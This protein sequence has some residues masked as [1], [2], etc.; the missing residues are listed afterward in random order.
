MLISYNWLQTYFDKKLPKVS[1][2]SEILTMHSFEVESVEEVNGDFVLDIDILPNRAHDCLSHRG[3]AGEVSSLLGYEL[4]KTESGLIDEKVTDLKVEV[5]DIACRRY[6]GKV[7]EDIKVGSSPDWLKERLEVIG[8]KS[9]NNIVDATNYV[10][11][12]TGQPLHAFDLDKLSGEKIIVRKARDGEKITTL[13]DKEVELMEEDLVIADSKS[14]LAI[15]GVKG[16]KKAEVDENT[17]RI[18]LESANFDPVGVRKTSRRLN[19]LTD[20][21]KRFE[22]E[23]TPRKAQEGM[24]QVVNLVASDKV[25]ESIDFYPRR[26]GEY[27]I[28]V[29]VDEVNRLLGTDL[30]EKDIEDILHR[31]GFGFEKVEDVVQKVLELAPHFVGVPY[32]Y[33]A[34][35]TYDAPRYFDCSSFT[36]YL[37]AQAGVAI[38]RIS[39]DQYVFGEEVKDLKAG[40]LVFSRGNSGKIHNETVEFMKG[41]KIEKG[42]NHCGIYLGDGR[43]IH[44]SGSTNVDKVVTEDVDKSLDFKDIVGYRRIVGEDR[45]VVS[46]PSER[47]DLRIKEDL[48]E[49]IGRVYG[50]KNIKAELPISKGESF[51]NKTLYYKNKIRNLLVKKGFSEVY[52]YSLVNSGEVELLNPLA[53]DKG[54]M[55]VNLSDGVKESLEKNS[56]SLPLLGLDEVKIFEFGNVFSKNEEH[57]SFCVG[58]SGLEDLKLEIENE[59]GAKFD[60]SMDGDISEMNF[61]ELV[62]KLPDQDSY[63][64]V[65]KE[66]REGI[67]Y[68]TMSQYPFVLRDIAVWVPENVESGEV[69]SIVKDNAGD[70]LIREGLFDEFKKDGKVSYA[71][72]LVFQSDDK[73]L[74]DDEINGIM[75]KITDELNSKPGWEVR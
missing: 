22:N 9:I 67:V 21:S 61:D 26:A 45:F 32:R 19:I 68:K 69:I 3:V 51:V 15:A 37:F 53:S 14:V 36:S 24:E 39:I 48:I 12:D 55:R 74:T 75:D 56:K 34:S 59:L 23:I 25:H 46:I 63:D 17:K 13:D 49:E 35:I 57:I 7:I 73:T 2:L 44:A 64:D 8:Q 20:S 66:G 47:V 62:N 28:G 11:F 16:G 54:F 31:L 42:I 60:V 40:D 72:N 65:I 6:I 29:S 52:N 41:E 50:Y 10:M 71:F 27:R 4:K 58:S 33:G 38:P 1:E 18:V 43:I 5:K 30:K 70:L